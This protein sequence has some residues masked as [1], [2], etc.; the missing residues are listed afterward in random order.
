MTNQE[1]INKLEEKRLQMERESYL[2][3]ETVDE[4]NILEMANEMIVYRAKMD[5]IDEIQFML[6]NGVWEDELPSQI[7]LK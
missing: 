2:V 4:Y 7:Y 1:L 6:L 3:M 5:M